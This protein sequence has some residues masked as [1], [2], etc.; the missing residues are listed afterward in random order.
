MGLQHLCDM[1]HDAVE[2]LLLAGCVSAS[3]GLSAARGCVRCGFDRQTPESDADPAEQEKLQ[4]RSFAWNE[5]PQRAEQLVRNKKPRRSERDGAQQDSAERVS[6]AELRSDEPQDSHDRTDLVGDGA[7]KT[8]GARPA[9][10][11]AWTRAMIRHAVWPIT[12]DLRS[13]VREGHH[14]GRRARWATARPIGPSHSDQTCV[15]FTGYCSVSARWPK[16]RSG[17]HRS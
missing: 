12:A 1:A 9:S 16:G 4:E 14:G 5:R 17:G 3:R 6:G 8:S 13:M 7:S 2:F 10:S 11:R 15:N